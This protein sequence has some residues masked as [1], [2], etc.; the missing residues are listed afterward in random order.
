MSI[1]HFFRKIGVS[2]EDDDELVNKKNYIVYEAFLMS[3]GGL[4]WGSICTV[5]ELHFQ[6]TIPYGYI[7]LSIIN[8][9][10]FHR[11]KW[12]F[13]SLT[14]Q[15]LISLLLPFFFQWSLGG[16]YASGG[17]MIWS[18]LS[19][20]ASLSYS[21]KNI[22][23]V[24]LLL[25]IFL[26]ILSGFFDGF[27]A[28][29]YSMPKLSLNLAI[30]FVIMNTA[31][32]SSLIFVLV[33]YFTGQTTQSYIKLKNTQDKLIN[34]EKLAALGQLSAGIA[35]EI[36]S[37][38]GAI[39]SISENNATSFNTLFTDIFNL[40]EK[41][42]PG[43]I[44]FFLKTYERT[45]SQKIY[46]TTKEE[47]K[48]IRLLTQE[49]SDKKINNHRY[50][51]RLLVESDIYELAT[52]QEFF[53]SEHIHS[54]IESLHRLVQIKKSNRIVAE[55]VERASRIVKAL[56]MYIHSDSSDK[57]QKSRVDIAENI[58]TVLALYRNRLK[59]GV[60]TKLNVQEN[61]P[62][63]L[64]NGDQMNQVWTNL[65][66]NACQAMDYSGILEISA[67]SKNSFIIV[68]IA[69]NG[70]GIPDEYKDKIFN[71]FFST[72]KKGE[73]S[74]LGLDIVQRIIENQNGEISFTTNID[75]GTTFIVQL[76]IFI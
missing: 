19:L 8:M 7:F 76:P 38:L 13:F 24:W 34:S 35:H 51:A 62:H 27:F 26:L 49:L 75:E 10:I 66:G 58:K 43:Q 31:I 5:L 67:Y 50:I 45:N 3:I 44:Q 65:I 2:P 73:G 14:F 52:I 47:R 57:E 9:Y 68:E 22:S 21:D 70:R 69:D 15:T 36:N 37:P 39:K 28:E 33:V 16:Y 56:K 63:A 6:S 61:L 59:K 54:I 72:K 23:F 42:S 53:N 40:F 74:G 46:L 4:L 18:L 64:A 12:F 25:Y 20:A 71:P 29:R 48:Y 41:L 30:G 60:E 32:V 11:T 55:S 17:V 1:I